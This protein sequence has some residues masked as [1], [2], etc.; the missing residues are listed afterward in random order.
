MT[1]VDVPSLPPTHPRSLPCSLGCWAVRQQAASSASIQVVKAAREEEE[2]LVRLR[3][4]RET[5]RDASPRP[6]TCLG[7][8]LKF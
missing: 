6:S 4:E 2:E 1:D 7:L 3:T 5:R 8:A